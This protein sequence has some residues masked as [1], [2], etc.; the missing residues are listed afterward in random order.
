M[1]VSGV[2]GQ[3]F[4]YSQ[5]PF[6]YSH[7]HVI[8][9]SPPLPSFYRAFHSARR[10]RQGP[11]RM[12][13]PCC[14]PQ[15]P[16]LLLV[17]ALLLV[18]MLPARE[19]FMTPRTPLT[20]RRSTPSSSSMTYRRPAT[21][22]RM[23]T[24]IPTP[25]HTL[26]LDG[27]TEVFCNR[28]INMQQIRAIGFDMDYTLA[29]YNLAFELLAYDGAKLK[30]VDTLGYP[31]AVAEFEYDS[32]YFRRGLVIDKERGN[33]IKMD[34]HKYVRQAYHGFSPLAPAVRK[35]LYMA[36]SEHIPLYTESTFVNIDTLFLLVD[37]YLFAQLVEYKDRHPTQI[38]HSYATIYAHIR[39]CVD[40]CHRDGVI[41]DRVAENPG[42]YI[43]PDPGMVTMLEQYKESGRKTFLVTN[44][45]WEY[46]DVVSREGG[47][48]GG[49]E[50]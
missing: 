45:L 31:P 33:V 19:A 43:I 29:Q 36:S 8:V 21:A 18:A 24:S 35:E 39:Q 28:E 6:N 25:G 34:R 38:K 9:A 50:G 49:R 14:R 47:R 46:T 10:R 26:M 41:K 5:N 3:G 16:A 48:E 44:S 12:A 20:G 17:V 15:R 2:A 32:T 30:L 22:L 23:T 4:W 7:H 42:G 40:L 11:R 1:A 13:S 37:A 27:E